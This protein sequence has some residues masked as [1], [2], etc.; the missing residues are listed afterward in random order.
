MSQQGGP[1]MRDPDILRNAQILL[2]THRFIR[3]DMYSF[4]TFGQS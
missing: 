2:T 3:R 4:T 1:V